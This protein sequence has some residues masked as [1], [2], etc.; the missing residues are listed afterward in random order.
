MTRRI[1]SFRDFESPY[2]HLAFT[3]R[4]EMEADIALAARSA[5]EADAVRLALAPETFAQLEG[6]TK[7]A[8]GRSVFGSPTIFVGDM[9]LFGNDR[10]DFV[11][12]HLAR[13][14]QAA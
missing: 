12:E 5:E 7:E 1:E 13:L 3:Q 10:L 2:S 14:E 11:R 6:N 4:R 9:M 8:A